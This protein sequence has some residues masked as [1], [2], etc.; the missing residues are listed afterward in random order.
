M[1]KN[2]QFANLKSHLKTVARTFFTDEKEKTELY[3]N[4]SLPHALTPTLTQLRTE[5]MHKAIL[6]EQ[7][8]H[9]NIVKNEKYSKKCI[10]D[11]AKK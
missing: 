10:T 9:L 1:T 6:F 4:L 8:G 11:S 3:F 7:K 5:Q 2:K